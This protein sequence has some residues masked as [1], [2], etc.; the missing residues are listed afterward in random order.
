MNA[1]R[2]T[3][4]VCAVFL[5][6]LAAAPAAADVTMKQKTSGKGVMAA[7]GDGEA[8]VYLKGL[9]FR[10]DQV[11]GNRRTSMLMDANG[12]QM[13]MINHD[14]KEA[15]VFDVA[16]SKEAM[17]GLVSISDIKSS[18]KPTGQTRQIAGS[19]CAVYDV[20]ISMPVKMAEMPMTMSMVGPY[21]LAK[22]A[23]GAA[24]FAAFYKAAADSGFIFGDPRAAKASPAPRAMTEMYRKLSE[25]GAV[26]AMDMTMKMEGEGPM[27]ALMAKMGNAGMSNEV[28]SVSTDP[29]AD[30]VFEIPAG[31]KINKR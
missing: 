29:I 15:D 10:T 26:Y 3:I 22:N 8:T 2:F 12:T 13:V 5:Y 11:S 14:K 1:V 17:A 19:T 31:Y 4:P 25:L 18:F 7:A 9:K 6:G 20:S 30:S 24:D 16:K 27:A 21:C 28:T 23:P